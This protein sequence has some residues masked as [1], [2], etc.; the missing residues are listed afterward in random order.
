MHDRDRFYI[1]IVLPEF[2]TFSGILLKFRIHKSR[3]VSDLYMKVRTEIAKINLKELGVIDVILSWNGVLLDEKLSL[4]NAGI[5]GS[6]QI[7][8]Y[9]SLQK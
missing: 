1:D 3:D 2:L 8:A 7:Q 6:T 4:I 9:Y 5:I